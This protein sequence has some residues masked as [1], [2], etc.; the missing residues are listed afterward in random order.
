MGVCINMEKTH[1]FGELDLD[2]SKGVGAIYDE[3]F[4]IAEACG[5]FVDLPKPGNQIIVAGSDGEFATI[6]FDGGIL[7]TVHLYQC[8]DD[9]N[10]IVPVHEIKVEGLN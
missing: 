5:Y 4:R 9:G 1:I 6:T 2:L 8:D 7:K 3:A 10:I